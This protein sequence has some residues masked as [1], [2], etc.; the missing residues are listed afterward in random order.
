LPKQEV[1][2]LIIICSLYGNQ[3]F[4]RSD[5]SW[6]KLDVLGSNGLRYHAGIKNR[7]KDK[8]EYDE[9][10]GTWKRRYGYD[11]A[12]DEENIPIIEAKMTDGK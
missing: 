4:S 8:T 10:T 7:K 11:R 1:S 3:I 9:Q 6:L 12:N 5:L 2:I